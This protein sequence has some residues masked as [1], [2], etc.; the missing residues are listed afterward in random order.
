MD[1]AIEF[2]CVPSRKAAWPLVLRPFT[3]HP[4]FSLR[5]PEP[6][7]EHLEEALAMNPALR[8]WGEP[9]DEVTP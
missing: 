3:Y 6:G 8:G 5:V 2:V 7:P 1:H 9:L 4:E